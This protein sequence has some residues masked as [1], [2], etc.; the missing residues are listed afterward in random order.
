MVIG[1]RKVE[2]PPGPDIQ[3][4]PDVVDLA[5]S[6]TVV[7]Q[8]RHVIWER[9]S[10]RGTMGQQEGAA[11]V[12]QTIAYGRRKIV[13]ISGTARDGRCAPREPCRHKIG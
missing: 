8:P 7:Q 2:P 13:D 5:L 11:A 12:D 10:I 1:T 6:C 4:E 9:P 3:Y